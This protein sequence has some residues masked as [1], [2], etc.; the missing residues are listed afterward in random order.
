MFKDITEA[1]IDFIENYIKKD[2]PQIFQS[3]LEEHQLE[4]TNQQKK[5]F[6][7]SY[8]STI[9]NFRFEL[10]ERKT[11]AAM[12]KYVKKKV[13]TPEE[14]GGLFHFSEV[15]KITKDKSFERNLIST[16]FGMVFGHVEKKRVDL[17]QM[18]EIK[19]NELFRKADLIFK[20]L[21]DGER[22]PLRDFTSDMVKISIDGDKLKGKVICPYCDVNDPSAEVC[23]YFK[24]SGNLV[25]SNLTNHNNR[26]HKHKMMQQKTISLHITPVN[27]IHPVV[28][29]TE[30]SEVISIED[31][32]YKQISIQEIKMSNNVMHNQET[33]LSEYF[34]AHDAEIRD[35]SALKYCRMAQNGDCLYLAIAHQLYNVKNNSREHKLKALEL[36]KNVV[37]HVKQEQNF[38]SYV[39]D[40][41]N[42]I[43]C[44]KKTGKDELTNACM[45]FLDNKLS[46][47]GNWGGQESFKAVSEMENV[48]IIVFN[49]DGAYNLPN[50]YNSRCDKAILLFFSGEPGKSFESNTDRSH[51]DSIVG[52]KKEKINAVAQDLSQKEVHYLKFIAEAP[53]RNSAELLE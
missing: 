50:H 29:A 35:E 48:N 14:N 9:T 41:K 33:G 39:H 12:V 18:V 49:D 3:A 25:P 7:G 2:L 37:A 10:G 23:L 38:E 34:G 1:D 27:P 28:V 45:D 21:R 32:L 11:L 44:D 30:S 8:V 17:T 42:R 5:C 36:R 52:L 40:L 16:V 22:K 47:S 53:N 20:N 13:D 31:I 46:K 19:Q 6:F 51:Y 24:S 15:S 4:Y 26:R 43:K